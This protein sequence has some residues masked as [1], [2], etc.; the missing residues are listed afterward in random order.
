MTSA[1]LPNADDSAAIAPAMVAN[2]DLADASVGY[3]R[4]SHPSI[5][6]SAVVG[7]SEIAVGLRDRFGR[8]H[9]SLRVS[10]TD[11]CNL[12]CTYCM[13]DG[14]VPF[15]PADQLLTFNQIALVIET[16]LELGVNKVRLTG[17]EPL[18]RPRLVELV[19][20]LSQLPRL[21]QLT[22]TTNGLRLDRFAKP[23]RQAGLQRLNISLDALDEATFIRVSRRSGLQRVLAGIDAALAAGFT[24]IR[25]NAISMR[26]ISE[27]QVLPLAEFARRNGLTVRFIEYMP[28]DAERGWTA[29]HVLSGAAV[30]QILEQHFGPL[31]PA[32]SPDP[33]QPATDYL[34][35]DGSGRIGL[36]NPVSE[37][38][39]GSCNRLRL[40]A[41]GRL[42]NCLFSHHEWD[43]RPA[44]H[45]DSAGR[46]TANPHQ[47]IGPSDRGE[48]STIASDGARESVRQAIQRL[49]H[50]CVSAKEAGHLISRHGFEQP[51]RAM[52][53]IGG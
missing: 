22:L 4:I 38:F 31:V 7:P 41:D 45:T 10:V 1:N 39:C 11:R 29:D 14:L 50:D 30:R 13:P 43:L 5:D 27:P 21:E 2:R 49:A 12:R 16:L 3:R 53:Q 46:P 19:A 47:T 17:G 33:H 36:I 24:D 44:L 28:L 34:Y 51:Q 25:L 9:D 26:G 37:P 23:L 40:T 35:A 52:Y 42:R 18:L 20:R 15:L 48:R 32:A 6:G 8:L